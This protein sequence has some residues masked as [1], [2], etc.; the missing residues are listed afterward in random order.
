MRDAEPLAAL[1]HLE[2][3][4]SHGGGLLGQSNQRDARLLVFRSRHELDVSVPRIEVMD[5]VLCFQRHIHAGYQMVIR[6]VRLGSLA[7]QRQLR[8]EH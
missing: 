3:V 5:L 8:L 1:V 6:V 7:Q 2:A 4:H